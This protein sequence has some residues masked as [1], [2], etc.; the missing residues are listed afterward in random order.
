M[1][2]NK[3]RLIYTHT[4]SFIKS[5]TDTHT[6]TYQIRITQPQSQHVLQRDHINY[7][8]VSTW[9]QINMQSGL[10]QRPGLSVFALSLKSLRALNETL[11]KQVCARRFQRIFKN[12]KHG[13]WPFGQNAWSGG[14]ALITPGGNRGDTHFGKA[15]PTSL[16]V[17]ALAWLIPERE[18]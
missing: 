15:P 18:V 2:S 12:A 10:G 16:L 3:S 1:Y 9:P 14:A 6:H 8:N 5:H 4:Y 13:M 17:Q 7:S 11:P